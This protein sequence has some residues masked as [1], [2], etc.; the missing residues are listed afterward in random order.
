MA[1]KGREKGGLAAA[2]PEV[3]QGF[4]A[5]YAYPSRAIPRV[6]LETAQGATADPE[7]HSHLDLSRRLG[8]REHQ[9]RRYAIPFTGCDLEIDTRTTAPTSADHL[10]LCQLAQISAHTGASSSQQRLD[11]LLL[12]RLE[13]TWEAISVI[14]CHRPF[15]HHPVAQ[16][17]RASPHPRAIRSEYHNGVPDLDRCTFE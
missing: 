11:E 12:L 8:V 7:D 10:E 17:H 9:G 14:L 5:G 6:Y 15:H 16:T 2:G 3:G 4:W 1:K 13:R